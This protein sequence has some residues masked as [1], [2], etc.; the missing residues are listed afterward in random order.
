MQ[1]IGD[2]YGSQFAN[3][4]KLLALI[5]SFNG[6]ID[7]TVPIDDFYNNIWNINTA[8]GYGLDVWGRIVGVTRSLDVPATGVFFG[9]SVSGLSVAAQPTKRNF[10][11]GVFKTRTSVQSTYLLSDSAFRTL[12][13]FKAFVNVSATDIPSLNRI[14]RV[15]L[16]GVS[17][18]YYVNPGYVLD[19]YVEAR[20]SSRAYVVDNG[21]MT[22]T[23]VFN[24][25]LT[26]VQL[27]IVNKPGLLPH[28]VGVA[29]SVVTS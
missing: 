10:G 19:G 12:I 5:E 22:M 14:A 7:P 21:N 27:A 3:S 16:G 24:F 20:D 8:R 13:L 26:P 29:V 11:H 23:Y 9:F 6:A 15:L 4:P 28:P 18:F 17:T 25:P 2:T 1:N